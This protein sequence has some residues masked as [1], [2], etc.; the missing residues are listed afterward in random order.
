M[1]TPSPLLSRVL[2]RLPSS[3]E[4]V[5]LEGNRLTVRMLVDMLTE[6]RGHL[7]MELEKRLHREVEPEITVFLLSRADAETLRVKLRGVKV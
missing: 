6:A 4:F 3:V 7:L 2:S 5:S 1:T